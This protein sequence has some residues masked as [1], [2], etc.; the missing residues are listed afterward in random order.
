MNQN[1]AITK[2][3]TVFAFVD[4]DYWFLCAEVG[5][6]GKLYKWWRFVLNDFVYRDHTTPRE[7]PSINENYCN[8]PTPWKKPFFFWPTRPFLSVSTAW[9]LKVRKC[10]LTMKFCLITIPPW[11]VT[12]LLKMWVEYWL[13]DSVFS[14]S[15]DG[16]GCNSIM[17]SSVIKIKG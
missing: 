8:V 11:K 4:L 6:W 10:W 16:Y 3:S 17:Q 1:A 2:A 14:Y 12:W 9:N 13:T 5:I 7:L 15:F